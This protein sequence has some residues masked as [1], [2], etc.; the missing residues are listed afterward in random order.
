MSCFHRGWD[1]ATGIG[2][3]LWPTAACLFSNLGSK[4]WDKFDFIRFL[5]PLKKHTKTWSQLL[6][7][8]GSSVNGCPWVCLLGT[9]ASFSLQYWQGEL[10]N[11]TWQGFFKMSIA[12]LP[13][14]STSFLLLYQNTWNNQLREKKRLI[15]DHVFMASVMVGCPYGFGPGVRLRSGIRKHEVKLLISW[16]G[17]GKEGQ[18]RGWSPASP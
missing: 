3:V 7:F 17:T 15:S 1:H 10:L 8:I 2:I 4:W 12:K 9:Q 11:K 18:K 13:S 16:P 14:V 5:F 6:K